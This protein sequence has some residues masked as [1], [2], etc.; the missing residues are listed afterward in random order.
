MI[1]TIDINNDSK[2]TYNFQPKDFVNNQGER[3]VSAATNM[4]QISLKLPTN[5]DPF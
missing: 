2:T 1:M 5:D 4:K 3:K